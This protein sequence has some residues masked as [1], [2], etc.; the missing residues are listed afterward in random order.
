MKILITGGANGIGREIAIH[1]TNIGYNVMIVDN[2]YN[3]VKALEKEH[4]FIDCYHTDLTDK[5][6][7]AN[8]KEEIST[9][10]GPIDVLINNATVVGN[11]I[12]SDLSYEEFDHVL[13]VGLKAPYEL[14]RLFKNDLIAS[15]GH[16]INMSSTR[17]FQ[18]EANYESYAV[19]KGGI[20]S[21]T[22][23]LAMS[24]SPHVKVNAIAPGW[25]NT[26]GYVPSENDKQAIPLNRVGT[27][28]D[29]IKA[30]DFLIKQDYITGEC[31]KIDGGMN[32]QLIYHNESNWQYKGEE[33]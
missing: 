11:G 24:L 13:S 5:I 27:S 25:I 14:A 30:I 26:G 19:V 1:Y 32:K 23:S 22:H 8:L 7:L 15:K 33:E 3:A 4:S 18:S 29:I 16:I 9:E 10:Y 31:L 21:L 28:A 20:V 12:L 2:D 17:A 6:A